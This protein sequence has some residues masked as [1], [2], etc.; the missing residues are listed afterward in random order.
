MDNAQLMFQFTLSHY[1]I[2][3]KGTSSV[4]DDNYLLWHDG[5]EQLIMTRTIQVD[6]I[7][8]VSEVFLIS[9]TD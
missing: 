8:A 6:Y 2:K 5:K 3:M 7:T 4:F 9:I 1:I